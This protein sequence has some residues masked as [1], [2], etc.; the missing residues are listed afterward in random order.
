MLCYNTR[1]YSRMRHTFIT[2]FRL[3]QKQCLQN[4]FP[5]EANS[6]VPWAGSHLLR[7]TRP[8]PISPKI[9]NMFY[10]FIR[11]RR[12]LI[13]VC[14]GRLCDGTLE[15]SKL[16][17]TLRID[18]AFASKHNFLCKFTVT[19]QQL[20]MWQKTDDQTVHLMLHDCCCILAP[21]Q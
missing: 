11:V 7:C 10:I 17:L 12:V 16:G 8:L 19:K 18:I 15:G 1:T 2:H 5:Y 21:H 6:A 3:M 14:P 13:P 9:M 4:I 20:F